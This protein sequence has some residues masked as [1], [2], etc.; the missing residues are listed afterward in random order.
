MTQI[1]GQAQVTDKLSVAAQY[2]LEWDTTRAPEGGTYLAGADVQLQGPN[3]LPVA[4]GFAL[5]IIDPKTP[6]N[7]GN[8]G[9][10]A[11]YSLDF[12]HSDISA[13]YREFDDYNPWGLQVGSDFARY[14]YAENVKQY[15]LGWAAG[16]V[17]G[18]ASVG[19]IC[20]IGRT[21]H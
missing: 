13:A 6:K 21:P 11:T 12:M 16:P 5:P 17:L 19:L 3:Q 18:G 9:V 8:W 7:A 20:H 10:M 2:F 15:S 1:S 14:I 4:P